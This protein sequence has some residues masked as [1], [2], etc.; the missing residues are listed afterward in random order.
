MK[1]VILA[2]IIVLSVLLVGVIASKVSD[3]RAKLSIQYQE[4]P[5]R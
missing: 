2:V 4:L 5:N 3:H 1:K